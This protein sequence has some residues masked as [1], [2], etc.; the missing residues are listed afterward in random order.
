MRS[1]FKVLFYLKRGKETANGEVMIMAR[2]T[3]NG[4][5]CQFSTKQKIKP[6][7]WSVKLNKAIGRSQ[8]SQSINNLLESIKGRLFQ[9]HQNLQ[10]R[11]NF[12][13]AEKVR[14]A[15][16][17]NTQDLTTLLQLFRKHNADVAQ[18]I[19]ISRAKGTYQK[20]EV[21]RKHIENFIRFKYNISDIYLKEINTMFVKDFEVYMLTIGNCGTNTVAKFMQFFKRII[22][23][24]RE[25]GLINT[26]PFA[27][28]KIKHTKVD[29]GYLTKAEITIIAQKEF[30]TERLE[31]VRDLFIFSCFCGLAYIDLKNL[32]KEHIKEGLDGNIWIITKRQ[33]TNTRVEVPLLPIPRLILEKYEGR[34]KDDMILP[35]ISNQ[36][37]NA[38]LK[39]IA[40]VCGIQKLLTFHLARHTF[41]TTTT[42]AA[43]IPI[44]TVSKMLGHTNIATTQIYARVTNDKISKDMDGLSEKFTEIENIVELENSK[45]RKQRVTI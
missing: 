41:A 3:V 4:E 1:T 32:K 2:I 26:N 35:I 9:I 30:P 21:T 11:D 22:I 12:V 17:G 44:E 23:I 29:R 43:G 42:L 31:Q 37:L 14:N 33:K 28:Y 6:A 27:N 13:T 18:L 15:F 7:N 39:E 25:N 34:L 10:L 40:D 38:Y 20:Y 19:G 36:K 45:P 8:E 5:V 24:A 16:T